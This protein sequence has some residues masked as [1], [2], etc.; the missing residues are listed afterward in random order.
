[1]GAW[2][3][4]FNVLH[5]PTAVFGRLKERPRIW[6][7]F[8]ILSVILV[9]VGLLTAPY[10]AAAME[11]LRSSLPAEQAA[12]MGGQGQSPLRSLVAP[13]VVLLGLLIGAGLLWMGVSLSGVQAKF[14]TLL[15]VLT[16]SYVTYLIYALVGVAV[17]MTR[18]VE[19]IT[20]I[21]DVRAPLGL[22]LLVPGASLFVGTFLNGINPFAVWGVWL[23]GTGISITH[24]TSRTTGIVVTTLVYLLCLLFM[25]APMLLL[26][27]MAR[28]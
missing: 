13:I 25:A 23:C 1:M 8:A 16:H 3:D 7:A 4:V 28:Q 12:R 10:Q 27:G 11:A 26:G 17:L 19:A 22:D 15:S 18:G 20:G 6:E 24:E 5:E 9:G 2:L 14:K 21:A